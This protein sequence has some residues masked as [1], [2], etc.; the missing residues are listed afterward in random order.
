LAKR[1]VLLGAPGA[2]K[3]TQA[4]L[5][6]EATGVAHISTGDM[7]RA[8]VKEGTE[9]G[10]QVQAIIDSGQLVPDAL[11]ISLI[12][13]R[14]AKADCV[15]GYILDGFPRTI[16]QAESLA[17][18]LQ[19]GGQAVTHVLFFNVSEAAV[20]SRLKN[21]A[22]QE[23]RVD[24]AENTQLERLRVYQAQ[25]APLIEYYRNAKLLTE[26]DGSGSVEEVHLNVMKCL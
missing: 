5:L 14:V 13:E 3:G 4:K 15:K 24:D 22:Q 21:R 18:M 8:A 26:I 25:T 23:G 9:L 11:I 16:V 17:Q 2:G 19:E 1:I 10:K 7:L 20:M 6:S 12:K